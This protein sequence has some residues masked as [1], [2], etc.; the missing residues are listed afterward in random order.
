M[1]KTIKSPW[2]RRHFVELKQ[3]PANRKPPAGEDG[4]TGA[5]KKTLLHWVR[6]KEDRYA[7]KE[8][9]GD[10]DEEEEEE[11]QQSVLDRRD[12]VVVVVLP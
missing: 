1:K 9:I 4:S 12:V 6:L 11:K 7:D 2:F 5:W 8:D 10:D 3:E